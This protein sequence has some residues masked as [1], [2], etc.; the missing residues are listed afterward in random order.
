MSRQ[1]SCLIDLA[2]LTC[3]VLACVYMHD[4]FEIVGY[5][6]WTYTI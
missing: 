3:G 2:D 1:L 4:T 6:H 5:L